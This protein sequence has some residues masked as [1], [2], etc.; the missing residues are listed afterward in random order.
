MHD[1]I[2]ILRR[3]G[4]A[5]IFTFNSDYSYFTFIIILLIEVASAIFLATS[6][7]DKKFDLVKNMIFTLMEAALIVI[8]S[9]IFNWFTRPHYSQASLCGW[10]CILFI[11]IYTIS[12]LSIFAIDLYKKSK[13]VKRIRRTRKYNK[14]STTR[15]PLRVSTSRII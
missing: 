6:T 15:A 12:S 11:G 7:K 3:T 13:E 9:V 4:F 8:I 14:E 5:M 2:F 1:I 10:V